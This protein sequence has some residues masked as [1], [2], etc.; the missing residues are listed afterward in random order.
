MG[1]NVAAC[2]E[3]PQPDYWTGLKLAEALPESLPLACCVKETTIVPLTHPGCARLTGTTIGLTSHPKSFW[4]CLFRV[5]VNE[6][7]LG[8]MSK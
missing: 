7:T 6:T 1:V 8:V 5:V 2:T 4:H 3:A